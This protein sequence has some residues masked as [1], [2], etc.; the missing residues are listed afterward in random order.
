MWIGLGSANRCMQNKRMLPVVQTIVRLFPCQHCTHHHASPHHMQTSTRLENATENRTFTRYH[1][2]FHLIL[3]GKRPI[4]FTFDFCGQNTILYRRICEC[5]G[6][7]QT[8]RKA[9]HSECSAFFDCFCLSC[10]NTAH[11]RPVD[12]MMNWHVADTVVSGIDFNLINGQRRS[13]APST[14]F[15]HK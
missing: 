14:R 11:I 13:S 7:R 5:L 15:S 12:S 1:V 9:I 4:N 3:L 6:P 10:M 2:S 8:R